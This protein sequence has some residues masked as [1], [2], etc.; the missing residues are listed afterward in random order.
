MYN[1]FNTPLIEAKRNAVLAY[2]FEF[3]LLNLY[4]QPATECM[5]RYP[6]GNVLAFFQRQYSQVADNAMLRNGIDHLLNF[7]YTAMKRA[8][9]VNLTKHKVKGVKPETFIW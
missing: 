8:F 7:I 2:A 1:D 4:Y 6:L 9:D 3:L 5:S